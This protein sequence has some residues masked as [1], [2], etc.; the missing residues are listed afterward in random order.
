MNPTRPPRNFAPGLML[1]GWLMALVG[2]WLPWTHPRP[3]ALQFNALD[4]SEWVTRL[5][6]VRDGTLAVGRLD[7]LIPLALL[8]LLGGLLARHSPHPTLRWAA[9]ILSALNL[10]ALLP[11]YPSILNVLSDPETRAQATLA[12]IT[13]LA[14][15]ALLLLSPRFPALL[16]AALAVA[17]P[18]AA[19]AV[20]LRAVLLLKP[21]AVALLPGFGRA[22]IGLWLLVVGSLSSA[23]GAMFTMDSSTRISR[24]SRSA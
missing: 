6:A 15:L 16:R 22:G 18:L 24:M 19:V 12:V 10:L 1:G 11:G 3:A 2:W 20:A 9:G 8:I 17:L 14:L 7:F 4:I 23:S 13:A 21:E 5:P